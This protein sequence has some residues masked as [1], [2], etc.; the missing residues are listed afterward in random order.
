MHFQ[1]RS[2]LPFQAFSKDQKTTWNGQRDLE[3][4]DAFSDFAKAL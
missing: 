4:C 3:D 2:F 1:Q